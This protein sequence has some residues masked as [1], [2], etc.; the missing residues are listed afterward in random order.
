MNKSTRQR[1]KGRTAAPRGPR[2]TIVIANGIAAIFMFVSWF[3]QNVY[4]NDLEATKSTIESDVQFSNSEMTKALQ[5]ML[6]FQGEIRKEKP[7]PEII[8]NSSIGYAET[9][10]QILEAA[11]RVDPRSAVLSGNVG[12]Y[13]KL[14]QPLRAAADQ[15]DLKE[16]ENT[17][18]AL[19]VWF[20]SI[21]PDAHE[22]INAKLTDVSAAGRNWKLIFIAC[23]M[24]GSVVYGVT[25][26][27]S[28]FAPANKQ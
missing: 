5:W 10:G 17:S 2:K 20:R 9:V 1:Q 14:Y 16:I 25:W 7:D 22:A 23:F 18:S 4:E 24:F 27:I 8:L 13:H 19:I 11:K 21:G 28:Y 26:W 6:A 3:S 12:E 15:R